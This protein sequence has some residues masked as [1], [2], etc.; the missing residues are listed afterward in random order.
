LIA[1]LLE[2][3]GEVEAVFGIWAGVFIAFLVFVFGGQEAI[4]YLEATSF[5]EPAFVFA[6]M[7]VAGTRPMTSAARELIRLIAKLIPL[8][9]EA[10]FLVSA[11]TVGTWIGSLITEPAAM[12]LIAL[13]LK[14]HLFQR[15][16]SEK[17][18]YGVLG[19]L[20]VNISIGGTLTH[21]AA[22][23]VVMV[24]TQWNWGM[25]DLFSKF[26]WKA[27][28]ATLTSSLLL[29]FICKK[30]IEAIPAKKSSEEKQED[31]VPLWL[32]GIH[33]FFLSLIV[34]SSHHMSVFIPLVLFFL[35][36]AHVTREFQAQ[37]AL[38]E[39]LMVGFFLG[40]L[41]VLGAPQRWWLEP[42]LAKLSD[43]SLFLSATGLTA[44]TDNAALTYLGSQVP[45]LSETMKY[46]LIAGAVTG[47]G[48][49]VIANAPNPAGY[50]ILN[51]AFGNKGIQAQKLFL[52]ALGPTLIAGIY[53]G[54]L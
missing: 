42:L 36:V 10:S 28:L 11:L 37:L 43:L 3:L 40:G 4:R 15:T 16:Q 32:V 20:F 52:A 44:I 14:D 41:M 2:L 25:F 8:H 19:T 22:P 48:L 7:L 30:D 18:K 51:S 50:G 47:G 38:R 33:S 29:V 49:T 53:F 45:H 9:P 24:A 21:F 1:N 54:V 34:V 46:A 12:T 6:V 27:M 26:G 31:R 35:G 13:I 17:L 39:S 5:V 23:P